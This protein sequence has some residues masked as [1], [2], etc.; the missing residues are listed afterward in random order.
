MRLALADASALN[1]TLSA[2]QNG[3]RPTSGKLELVIIPEGTT[4]Y[5]G[6]GDLTLDEESAKACVDEFHRRRLKLPVDYEHSTILRGRDGRRAPAVGWIYDMEYREGEGIV[7]KISIGPA[8]ERDIR[9]QKYMYYSPVVV[10][11]TD[12]RVK[13]IHSLALTNKPRMDAQAAL[14][15][16]ASDNAISLMQEDFSVSGYSVQS[17]SMA[18]LANVLGRAGME[19]GTDYTIEALIDLAIEW[20]TQNLQKKDDEEGDED[21]DEEGDEDEDEEG[22]EDEDEESMSEELREILEL[23]DGTARRSIIRELR[24]LKGAAVLGE[25]YAELQ[26]R[27]AQLEDDKRKTAVDAAIHRFTGEGRLNPNDETQM[28]WARSFA[29]KDLD[30]FTAIM[31]ESPVL[32]AQGRINWES[33]PKEKPDRQNII[34]RAL[35]SWE[36]D[37]KPISVSRRAH[38]NGALREAGMGPVS[39]SEMSGW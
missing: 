9:E 1:V 14:R 5:T 27:V 37:G 28:R 2:A 16:A 29:E 15:L 34:N 31:A 7:A 25:N 13:M 10:L 21:E 11:D 38:V 18:K 19:V 6:F 32:L 23:P 3:Q 39:A 8:A 4:H 24:K 36:E 26:K 33:S 20:I 22:D 12:K 17:E 35:K 30:G